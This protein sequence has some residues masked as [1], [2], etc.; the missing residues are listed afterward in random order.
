M[1]RRAVRTEQRARHQPLVVVRSPWQPAAGRVL[2]DQLAAVSAERLTGAQVD[3]GQTRHVLD[4]EQAPQLA[5]KNSRVEVT[6]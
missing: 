6:S 1:A 4:S 3:Q 2:P 5:L